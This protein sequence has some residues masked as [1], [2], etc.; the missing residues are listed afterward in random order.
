MK[1][2]S[3]WA[4][5]A[6]VVGCFVVLLWQERRRPLRKQVEPRFRHI[7][8]NFAL[9][10]LAAMITVL[11]ESPLIQPLAELVEEQRL[12]IIGL[13]RLSGFT[14]A[15]VALILMDYTFYVWHVLLHR[16]PILWRFHVVHHVDL[17]LDTSTALRFHFGELLLS[18]PW[19]AAQVLIIGLSP[20]TFSIWQV[21]FA[22]CVMFH[23]SNLRLSVQWERWMNRLLVT[24]RMHG[25]HHSDVAEETNSNWS[26][27]LTVWDWLHGTLRLNVPQE[28]IEIGVPAFH[29]PGAVVLPALIVMPFQEQPDYWRFPHGRENLRRLNSGQ[30]ENF[31]PFGEK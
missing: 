17:D 26:S 14:E 25:I 10:G 2:L 12:G 18:V 16:A 21:W 23:H 7:G 29:D 6:L 1:R 8:R 5:G 4:A 31:E 3:P 30:S 28:E 15:A 11:F 19:R 24:P 13:F 27:G 20:A 22:L 9:A